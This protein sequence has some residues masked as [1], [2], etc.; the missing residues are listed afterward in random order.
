SGIG[1]STTGLGRCGL[2]HATTIPITVMTQNVLASM[3]VFNS[4][5]HTGPV[6]RDRCHGP[7]VTPARPTRRPALRVT[8]E[9]GASGRRRARG[10]T[11]RAAA[12][13][14]DAAWARR[15]HGFAL[16]RA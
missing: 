7:W 16:T 14:R 13:V 12:P 2:A 9:T 3:T 4:N 11:G 8:G 15:G 6:S 1:A 10:R 5:L